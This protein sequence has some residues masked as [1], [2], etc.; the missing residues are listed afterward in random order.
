MLFNPDNLSF[1]LQGTKTS[2]AEGQATTCKTVEIIQSMRCMKLFGKKLVKMLWSWKLE[3][4]IYQEGVKDQQDLMK[5]FVVP[6][7]QRLH[8]C[9]I[10]HFIMNVLI[11]LLIVFGNDIYDQPGYKI[12]QHLEQLLF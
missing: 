9:I 4:L 11:Q 12:Y 7:I 5:A 10:D 3:S 6:T 8:N 2:A 1:T